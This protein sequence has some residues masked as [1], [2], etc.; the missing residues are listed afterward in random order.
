MGK[1]LDG[2][3]LEAYYHQLVFSQEIQEMIARIRSS[4]PSDALYSTRGSISS[5][6]PSQKM[7]RLIRAE[8]LKL[9]FP[10]ILEFESCNE[11]E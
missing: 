10:S 9:E 11:Y 8:S 3:G 6:Y 1:A 2:R 7:G 5:G 4:W